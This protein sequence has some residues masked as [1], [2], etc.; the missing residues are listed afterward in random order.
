MKANGFWCVCAALD[1]PTRIGLL[2]LLLETEGYPCVI[3]IAEEM[4]ISIPVASLYLKQLREAQLVSCKRMDKRI[5][6][7]AFSDGRAGEA[8][9]GAF[10]EFFRTKPSRERVENL[11]EYVHALSH[12]RRNLFVRYFSDHPGADILSFCRAAE[13]P[14]TTASRIFDQLNRAHIVDR[15]FCV[16]PPPAEPERTLLL[17]TA[18]KPHF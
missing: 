18:E 6:Y 13:V 11:L 8:I 16:T 17:L 5:Y 3:E 14:L 7:R 15:S 9:V 4:D 1:N 2:R 10:K 12:P